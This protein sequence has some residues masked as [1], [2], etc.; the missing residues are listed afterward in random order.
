[1]TG[2]NTHH[3]TTADAGDQQIDKC[4]SLT[5]YSLHAMKFSTTSNHRV[6]SFFLRRATIHVYIGCHNISKAGRFVSV[7]FTCP[8]IPHATHGIVRELD[9]PA[10]AVPCPVGRFDPCSTPMR[11]TLDVSATHNGSQKVFA[12]ITKGLCD[13][14]SPTCTLS[15]NGY[16]VE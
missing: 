7:G 3:Y 11:N 14:N 12:P 1:M 10:V 4:C 9:K 16:G 5:G 13:R 2:G 8:S 15:Q 6:T